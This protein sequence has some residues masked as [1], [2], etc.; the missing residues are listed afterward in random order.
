MKKYDVFISAYESLEKYN[1]LDFDKYPFYERQLLYTGYI[2][3]FENLFEISW[4]LMKQLIEYE[5][6]CVSG[7]GSPAQILQLAYSTGIIDDSDEWRKVL[8]S[9]NTFTHH[10]EPEEIVDNAYVIK[11]EYSPLFSSL[12]NS[13]EI[14]IKE[15]YEMKLIPEAEINDRIISLCDDTLDLT[16]KNK[17]R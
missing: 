8:K 12:K 13:V 1:E 6:S 17:N 16:N 4:K 11:N 14:K 3:H 10:Y 9:R 15:L 2:N 5:G 7:I